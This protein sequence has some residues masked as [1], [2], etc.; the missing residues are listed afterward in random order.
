MLNRCGTGRMDAMRLTLRLAAAASMACSLSWTTPTLGQ[1]APQQPSGTP[2]QQPTKLDFK[3]TATREFVTQVLTQIASDADSAKGFSTL[4]AR[5]DE[6]IAYGDFTKNAADFRELSRGLRLVD[7]LHTGK[8][9]SRK[10]RATFF[11]EHPKFATE[12]AFLFKPGVDKGEDALGV[13]DTLG[14]KFADKFEQLPALA[15]A[16]CVVF[17]EPQA[18]HLNENTVTAAP[19]TDVFAFLADT[20]RYM[21]YNPKNTPAEL[22]VYVVSVTSP[23]DQLKMVESK[24]RGNVA[25]PA[26][27]T[28]VVYDDDHF[29]AGKPKKVTV[30]GYSLANIMKC[31]GVCIDQAYFAA[32]VGKTLGVPTVIVTGRGNDVGH[33][34]LGYLKAGNGGA[35]WDMTAGR[36]AGY[37]NVIGFIRDPQA[38]GDTT[39]GHLNVL[40]SFS[41]DSPDDRR[42]AAAFVDAAERVNELVREVKNFPPA[43]PAWVGKG[44]ARKPE[45][46][47][48]LQF[49]EEA[50]RKCAAYEPIW[51]TI[52]TLADRG[53]LDNA[54]R[55]RW[56]ELLVNWCGK[57]FPDFTGEMLVPLVSSVEDIKEQ[58]R[59]WDWAFQKFASKP[60]VAA[61]MRFM[62]ASMWDKAQRPDEAWKCYA[63]VIAKFP[64]EGRVSLTAVDNALKLLIAHDRPLTDATTLVG[65]AWRK[66]EKPSAMA[67]QFGTQ[68]VWYQMGHRYARLLKMSGRDQE[69]LSVERGLASISGGRNGQG[70]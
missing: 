36:Y 16:C 41:S 18:E 9:D 51:N 67:A 42:T 60:P 1:N 37:T 58:D 38:N 45:L 23:I 10:S 44:D 61:M 22:L 65:D 70:Q 13:M 40:A 56:I 17:D 50:G 48:Q 68:S 6:F 39:E 46:K 30:A 5:L 31:G 14:A 11:L 55:R 54:T 27:Y 35:V 32:E 64:N 4:R 12:L 43:K 66:S 26:R 19:V 7:L 28:D 8:P 3:G 15:A 62:N 59:L 57:Q 52:T 24:F 47:T 63:E 25:L 49:L 69:A 33:A 2:A 20:S 53:S 29:K 21:A 34:W